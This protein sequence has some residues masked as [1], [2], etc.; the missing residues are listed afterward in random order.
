MGILED[1]FVRPVTEHSGYNLVNTITYAIVLI[2]VLFAVYKILMRMKI[3]LDR[4][5]WISLLPF[6]F[7]GGM[8]R[9]LQDIN[10]FGFLGAYHALFVTPMI[11]IMIFLLAFASLLISR[12]FWAGFTKHFGIALM[13]AA[14]MLIAFNAKNPAAL[15]MILLITAASYAIFYAA[16]KYSKISLMGKWKS[17]NSQIMTAHLLDASAAFVAVSIVGGYRESGIFTNFLFSQ[18]P[19]WVFIPI[20]AA[21]VLTVIYFID[22]EST[23]EMNW[24]LKLAVLVLGLGPGIHDTF[25]VLMGSNMI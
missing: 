14:A 10:F 3:K 23:G 20:K 24:L 5:L 21:V 1:F 13:L 4:D 22:K 12:R 18:I 19:G 7:L 11:Y 15:A 16:L 8:L 2:V 9:A 6:V 17:F 25:S